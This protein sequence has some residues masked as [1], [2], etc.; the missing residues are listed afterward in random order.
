[1]ARTVSSARADDASS[2][3]AAVMAIRLRAARRLRRVF[4]IG[5]CGCCEWCIDSDRSSRLPLAVTNKPREKPEQS[6]KLAVSGGGGAAHPDDGSRG[7]GRDRP[8]HAGVPAP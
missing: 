4:M 1:M 7:K 2:V 8:E 3:E 5:S 6:T